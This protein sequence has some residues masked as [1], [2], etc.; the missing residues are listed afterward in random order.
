MMTDRWLDSCLYDS[1][2]R[3]FLDRDG[4]LFGEL[5]RCLRSPDYLSVLLKSGGVERLRRLRSEADYYGLQDSLVRM[6][7]DVCVGKKV[8]L[9]KRGWARVAGGCLVRSG[10]GELG[11]LRREEVGNPEDNGAGDNGGN[12]NNDGEANEI[13]N[14]PNNDAAQV[15]DEEDENNDE[16]DEEEADEEV[17]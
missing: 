8:I 2:G 9:E 5:L 4:K 13:V 12:D 10:A 17:S 15:I 16:A 6:I 14:E 7:D 11:G 3:I 1:D